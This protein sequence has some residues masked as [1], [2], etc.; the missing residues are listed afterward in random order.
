MKKMSL[1]LLCLILGVGLK[2]QHELGLSLGTSH[3][4][5]DFGGG[6]GQGTIFLKD[7]DLKATRPEVGVFYR[8][9]FARFFAVR[10]QFIYGS[11]YSNDIYSGSQDRY[12]RGMQSKTVLYDLSTQF[13]FHFVPLNLCCNT[14]RVSPYIA[15]G[16]GLLKVNPETTNGDTES[17]I[18]AEELQFMNTDGNPIVLNLP[19][20]FGLKIKTPKQVIIGLEGSYRITL[21]D[22]LDNYIRQ[23]NDHYL[24]VNANV[25]YVFCKNKGGG[26]MSK[27][28]SCPAF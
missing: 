23:Q 20:S 1:I 15:G 9:N 27:D 19:L 4:L 17:G 3:L 10:A 28:M 13:E 11:F 7:L 5:G 16:V 14:T 21:S 26:R 25:S 24:F 22:K 2:A 12:D 6:P 8:Y 18:A